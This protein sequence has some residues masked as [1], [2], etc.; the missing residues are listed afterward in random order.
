MGSYSSRLQTAGGTTE[1]MTI[2]AETDEDDF[3]IG[4]GSYLRT[5]GEDGKGFGASFLVEATNT[6]GTPTVEGMQ[7]MAFLGSVGGSEA[8]HLKTLGGDVTAGMYAAWFKIGSNGNCVF[9]SGSRT[10]VL[11]VDN[12]LSGT[13]NGKHYAIFFSQGAGRPDAVF[14]FIDA[15]GYDYLIEGDSATV[16]TSTKPYDGGAVDTDGGDSDGSIKISLGGS[17]YL[18][19]YFAA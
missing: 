3:L 8:A 15:G 7:C 18:I 6:T 12:Q 13:I 19:P 9:D 4:I 17:T 5:S 14:G 1:V 2:G 11:W 10:A 16:T